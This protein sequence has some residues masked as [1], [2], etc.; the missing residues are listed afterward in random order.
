MELVVFQEMVI[1]KFLPK[2]LDYYC[3]DLNINI[4]YLHDLV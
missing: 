1:T 4:Q 2:L 3:N